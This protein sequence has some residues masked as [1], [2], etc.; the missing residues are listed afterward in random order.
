MSYRSAGAVNVVFAAI[1]DPTRRA[2]VHRLARK[3]L[4]AGELASG[5][6][7]SRPAVSKHVRVLLHAGLLRERREGRHRFYQ[8]T[9]APLRAVDQWVEPYRAFWRSNLRNLKSYVE[10]RGEH[11]QPSRSER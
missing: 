11:E 4:T 2:I 6:R 1:A 10:T 5:F 3:R 9:P 8:L 7:M